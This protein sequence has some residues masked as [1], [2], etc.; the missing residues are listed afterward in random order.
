MRVSTDEE[1]VRAVLDERMTEGSVTYGALAKRLGLS[2]TAAVARVSRLVL[3]G[4]LRTNRRAGAIL[5]HCWDLFCWMVTAAITSRGMCCE[6][7]RDK[8]LESVKKHTLREIERS[9]SSA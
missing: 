6:E 2:K 9:T 4:R 8:I 7:C 1:T 5:P 3:A